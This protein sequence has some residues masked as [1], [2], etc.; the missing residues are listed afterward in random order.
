[1]QGIQQQTALAI[2]SLI[3]AGEKHLLKRK[4]QPPK[5]RLAYLSTLKA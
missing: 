1:V 2:R 3:A 5:Y 4:P